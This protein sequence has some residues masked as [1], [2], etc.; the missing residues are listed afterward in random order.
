[1]DTHMKDLEAFHSREYLLQIKAS[2]SSSVDLKD[3]L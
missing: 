1:M 3:L 2:F